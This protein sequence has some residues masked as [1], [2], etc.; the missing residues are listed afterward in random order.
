MLIEDYGLIGD[1]V[2]VETM[3]LQWQGVQ[4]GP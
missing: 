4:C 2:P 3:S 1:G